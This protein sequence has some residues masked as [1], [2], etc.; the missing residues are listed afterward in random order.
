MGERGTYSIGNNVAYTYEKVGEIEGVKVLFGK[1]GTGL[2]DLPAESHS[3]NMYIKLHKDGTL[4]MLRI[5]GDDHCLQAEIAYHPEP[6][7]T[8]NHSP[9]LHIHYYNHDFNRTNAK[10]LN[11]ATFEKYKK[12]LIGRKWY[13]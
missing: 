6:K 12:Y 9:V 11:R 1:E 2:H 7:L 4:N 13:D 3:S 8:G 10:Y 5:Y